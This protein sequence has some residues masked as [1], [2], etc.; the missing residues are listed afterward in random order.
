MTLLNPKRYYRIL[1]SI[2]FLLCCNNKAYSQSTQIDSLEK[3]VTKYPKKDTVW[4][5]NLIKLER[6]Y[7]I[8]KPKKIGTYAI[9][10]IENSKKLNFSYGLEKGL[11]TLAY[12]YIQKGKYQEATKV[13]YHGTFEYFSPNIRY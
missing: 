8:Q 5:K 12:Q 2:I 10:I 9:S 3:W 6:A 13:I 7:Y 11:A 1:A 4:V